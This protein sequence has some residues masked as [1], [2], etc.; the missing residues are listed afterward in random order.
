MPNNGKNKET[1]PSKTKTIK[2]LYNSTHKPSNVNPKIIAFTPI[3]LSAIIIL[4]SSINASK[5]VTLV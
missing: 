5:T 1:K 4:I 2:K 3:E